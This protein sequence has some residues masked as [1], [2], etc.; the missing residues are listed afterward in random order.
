MNAQTIVDDSLVNTP[1]KANGGEPWPK[2][3]PLRVVDIHSFLQMNIPPR[4]MMVEPWLPC[5]GLGMI[6]S[7][8]G[9][10]KTHLALGIAY[11]VASGSSVLGWRVPKAR[12]VLY[13]DGEMLAAPLQE[14]LAGIVRA[15]E[16]EPEPGMLN[17]ITPDLQEGFMPDLATIGGQAALNE[18][19]PAD[20]KLVIVDSLSSL[21]RGEGRENDAESWL[22]VA[23]WA[24]AQRVAGRSVLF[25]HHAGKGGAQRGTSKREDLL[26]TTLALRPPGDHQPHK[27]AR[28]EVHIEKS[29]GLCAE[30]VPVEAELVGTED[31]GGGVT[32]TSRPIEETLAQRIAKMAEDGMN[33]REIAEELKINRSTVYRALAKQAAKG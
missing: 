22:P 33:R 21:V 3:G 4:E 23:E 6:Y 26:D 24:L 14:R 12:K 1:V 19:I 31:G 2:R 7:P 11:A 28:F 9:V 30:F 5:Q 20:T 16:R 15:S 32:W 13:L 25:L 17:I 8:R 10:G 29:R 27:G 18:V